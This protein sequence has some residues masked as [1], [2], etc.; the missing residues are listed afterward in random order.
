MNK[1]VSVVIPTRQRNE[2]LVRLLESLY[3]SDFTDF[4]TI[5]VNDDI[6]VLTKKQFPYKNLQV[7][8]NNGNKGLAYS[9]NSG[10]RKSSG[11]YVLFIDDDNVVDKHML[12]LLYKE[13]QKQEPLAAIGPVTY[14]YSDKKKLWFLGG[15][16]NIATTRAYF[17]TEPVKDR[18]VGATLFRTENLHNCFMIRKELGDAVG[19]FDEKLFMGGTEFDLFMRIKKRNKN[20]FLATHIKAQCYHDTAEKGTDTMRNLGLE[21]TIWNCKE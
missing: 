12:G 7:L 19:W 11:E 21:T 1:K 14:F 4:E 3:A 2:K 17:F 15:G 10:A 5:I 18:M 13:I 16:F 8:N 6:K 9:R 20:Y